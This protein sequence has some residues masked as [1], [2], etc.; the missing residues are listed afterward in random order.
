MPYT[1]TNTWEDLPSTA[2]PIEAEDLNAI[3]AGIVTAT[4]LIE[5][6]TTDPTAAHAA[7]AIS[8]SSSTLV[9]TGTNVQA[10][11]EEMDDA[12]AALGGGVTDGD[13][14]DI[15]VSASGATWTIDAGVVTAAK[16]AADVATQ[17]ELDAEAVLARNADNLTSGTVADARIAS[18]IARDSEVTSAVAAEATLARNGDNITS[19]TVA[20]ARIASTIARDT[21]VDAKVSDTAYDATTWNGVTTIA[22]SKNAVRDKMEALPQIR[23][24]GAITTDAITDPAYVDIAALPVDI[25]V[26]DAS[27]TWTKPSGATVVYAICIG[28]GGGGASGMKG[29]AGT[30]R[31]GGGGGQAGFVSQAFFAAASCGATETVTIGAAG[32]GGAAVTADSTNGNAGTAGSACT[33]GSL[34]SG[35]GG[36]AASG[37]ALTGVGGGSQGPV[38]QLD[39]V[40][41]R[42]G[43]FRNSRGGDSI[44]TA[45]PTTSG[46]GHAGSGG[47]GGGMPI[48]NTARAGGSG[49]SGAGG[50]AG[51]AG[52]AGASGTA[53]A[54]GAGTAGGGGG[55]GGG[56][57]SG[58]TVGA[59]GA[60]G[61][62]GG[63]GGGGGSGI[64]ATT[65]SGAGAAGAAGRVVVISYR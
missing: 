51:T 38:L 64:N 34:L 56:A 24:V 29:A 63:G 14:G 59:G 42:R 16:V 17:A 52:A 27:G 49:G 39:A 35:S 28:S 36:P 6:H 32:T 2:T 53:G 22:P 7:T 55:S 23:G 57:A 18:T 1:P 10:V 4:D 21:E 62:P 5:T 30:D 26:F 25:Q 54:T 65:D 31:T 60:G 40:T 19:G 44:V 46:G 61:A 41:N 9:G 3:E 33:F 11:F 43:S 58:G 45:A 15:T 13:K 12:I 48:A 20:D 50:V 37:G 47:A 8:V